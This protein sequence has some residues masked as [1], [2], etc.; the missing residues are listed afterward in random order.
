MNF[1]RI[2]NFC[3]VTGIV[4]TMLVLA[5]HGFAQ[6][7][8]WGS[9][10]NDVNSTSIGGFLTDAT[11]TFQLGTF[12]DGASEFIP[13]ETNTDF[14]GARWV[15]LDTATYNQEG[16]PN[17]EQGFFSDSWIVPDNAYQGYQAY[18]WIF[19]NQ[20]GNDTSEWVLITDNSG[21]DAWKIPNS[22]GSQQNFPDQ[23]RVSTATDPIFGGLNDV[24][25]PGESTGGPGSFALKTHTFLPVPE[26]GTTILFGLTLGTLVMRRGRA[27]S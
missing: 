19:N 26:T 25:G 1:H 2:K 9:A 6:K 24:S 14:W 8:N 3:G 10:A 15:A 7:I 17:E 23:W 11:F 12:A 27:R 13:D 18:I 16:A 4:A 20:L 22:T 21:I 5:P